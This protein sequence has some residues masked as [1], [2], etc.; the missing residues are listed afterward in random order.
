MSIR[1]A[2]DTSSTSRM[3]NANAAALS[4]ALSLV[5]SWGVRNVHE[6]IA[7]EAVTMPG[8]DEARPVAARQLAANHEVESSR[9]GSRT[10]GAPGDPRETGTA[11]P[12]GA[13]R[14]P[15]TRHRPDPEE[16]GKRD[17]VPRCSRSRLVDRDTDQRGDD[18]RN[19]EE[20]VPATVERSIRGQRHVRDSTGQRDQKERA[21]GARKRHGFAIGRGQIA[22][23][24]KTLRRCVYCDSGCAAGRGGRGQETNLRPVSR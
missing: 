9:P 1:A 16:A 17:Q 22:I 5:S 13:P 24:R 2:N 11:R 18:R 6:T 15:C 14:R 4:S 19:R 3:R 21:I 8:V 7:N 20:L 10:T 12:R 23:E